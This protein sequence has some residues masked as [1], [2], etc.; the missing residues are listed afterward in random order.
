VSKGKI[1]KDTIRL[2]GLTIE[3]LGDDTILISTGD[4]V[5]IL[6][7]EEYAFIGGWLMGS[8][9]RA[10]K[11]QEAQATAQ[12]EALDGEGERVLVRKPE[13]LEEEPHEQKRGTD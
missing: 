12:K 13:P 11:N 7:V 2:R 10:Q 3:M 5:E 6:S 1:D 4:D 9:H 8:V